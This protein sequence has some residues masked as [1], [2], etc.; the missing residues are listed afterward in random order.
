MNCWICVS[1][2]EGFAC[3]SS[4]AGVDEVN[5]RQPGGE[6]LFRALK[7]RVSFLVKF[8]TS[9]HLSAGSFFAPARNELLLSGGERFAYL[10]RQLSEGE[11]EYLISV[12]IV[13]YFEIAAVE[14][15]E[16]CAKR[17]L[18]DG[19]CIWCALAGG[20]EGMISGDEHLLRLAKPPVATV[21]VAEVP[22]MEKS[23]WLKVSSGRLGGRPWL[24]QRLSQNVWITRLY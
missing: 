2:H 24:N 7:Q 12:K 11:I 8:Y 22:R 13:L 17:D 9:H 1:Y 19:Q 5:F 23:A 4:Q 21:T 14:P 6:T 3:V 20:V 15:G 10:R 16:P 18:E